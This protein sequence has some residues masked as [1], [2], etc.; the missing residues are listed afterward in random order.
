MVLW[1]TIVDGFLDH[2]NEVPTMGKVFQSAENRFMRFYI[3]ERGTLD[4]YPPEINPLFQDP[5][6]QYWENGKTTYL[7]KGR[8]VRMYGSAGSYWKEFSMFALYGD[9]A[10]QP[11]SPN[12]GDGGYDPWHNGPEDTIE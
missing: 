5:N 6:N 3:A 11:Y 12:P 9:P 7:D 8:I 10:F 1:S 2:E 4:G